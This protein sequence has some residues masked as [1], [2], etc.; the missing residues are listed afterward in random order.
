MGKRPFA[1]PMGKQDAGFYI[2]MLMDLEGDKIKQLQARL[3]H[4]EDV[5]RAQFVRAKEPSTEDAAAQAKQEEA[6]R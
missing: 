2:V 6:A 3:K 5:F 1:R 4:N